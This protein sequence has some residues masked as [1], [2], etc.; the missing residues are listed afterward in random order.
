MNAPSTIF[1]TGA[2]GNQG[3]AV[4]R[5]L[6]GKGIHIKALTRDEESDKAKELRALGVEVIRGNLDEPSGFNAYLKG[7]DGVYSVQSMHKGAEREIRQGINLA[8]YANEHNIPHIIYSSTAGA[9]SQTG[10]P[11]FESKRV[12]E[13]HFK[14]TG[15]RY[16]II[17]PCSF[18]E[19]F[20]LPQVKH[21]L[22]KGK[23]V[24]PV[25]GETVQQFIAADDVGKLV[26]DAFMNP[27]SYASRTITLGAEELSIEQTAKVF[28]EMLN[29]PVHYQQ[30]PG[31]ITRLAMG[32]NLYAMFKWINSHDAIFTDVQKCRKEYPW[33]TDLKTWIRKNFLVAQK[34]TVIA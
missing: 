17:R 7:V 12:I 16:T 24:Y 23:L 28:S 33:L 30:L 19:N 3:G 10:I 15:L 6:L 18:Y 1:V 22:L 34:E 5:H 8:D 26:V 27:A 25:S 4:V 31:I 32:K 29:I 13:E 14:K 20:L 11:H 21:R 2:T 9:T